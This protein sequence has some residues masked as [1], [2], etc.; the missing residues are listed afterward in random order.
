MRMVMCRPA[1]P[2]GDVHL[3]RTAYLPTNSKMVFVS[4]FSIIHS[5]TY[6]VAWIYGI[7][8]CHRLQHAFQGSTSLPDGMASMNFNQSSTIGATTLRSVSIEEEVLWVV[9]NTRG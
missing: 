4:G 1:V 6:F 8:L 2:A 9:D 3:L 5:L 7:A